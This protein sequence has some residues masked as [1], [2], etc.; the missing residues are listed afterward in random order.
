VGGVTPSLTEE[1]AM[2]QEQRLTDDI[3]H[4]LQH[5]N[6]QEGH[7]GDGQGTECDEIEEIDVYFVRRPKQGEGE[8]TEGEVSTLQRPRKPIPLAAL[9]ALTVNLLLTL[10]IL[11]FVIVPELT[12]TATIT[13][14]PITKQVSVTASLIVVP[15]TPTS[16]QI[17]ARFLPVFTLTQSQTLPTTGH[18]HQDAKH[19][20]GTLTFYNSQFQTV[21]IPAGTALT[22]ASGIEIVTDQDATIPA[23]SQTIPPTLGQTTVSAHALVPGAK[24]NI[25]TGDIN[26]QCC[27]PSLLAQNTS[28]FHGGQD[29]RSFQTVAKSDIDSSAN[30]LKTTLVQSIQGAFQGQLQPQEHLHLLPCTTTVRSDHRIGAEATQVNVTMSLTCSAVAYNTDWLQAQA[31]ALLSH[32]V[33]QQLGTGYSVLGNPQVTVTQ[34]ILTHTTPTLVISC[35]GIWI[36][37]LSATAQQ[38][39]KRAIA[40]KTKQDALRLL[41]SLPGIER[42]FI[43]WG[44]DTK[45]PT[46]THNI[47]VVLMYGI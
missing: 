5:F 12:A 4:L 36:Y 39:I 6:E 31:T 16:G 20:T 34:A 32:Q 8:T 15:G 26:Q 29:E 28:A 2:Q 11:V 33:L 46:D 41:L 17:P 10:S 19:A 13:L 7:V 18:G 47:H 1:E 42:A 45:L 27:A 43:A 25:P 37:E 35:Q 24:G 44:D 9:V 30:Q 21:T 22:G 23:E 14:I 3:E 38:R 40:G